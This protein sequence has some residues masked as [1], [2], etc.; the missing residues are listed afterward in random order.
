MPKI[1]MQ[2]PAAAA[3]P[4]D[5]G[6]T[7]LSPT[8]KAALAK[9]LTDQ[10]AQLKGDEVAN[11]YQLGT[12]LARLHKGSLFRALGQ[13]ATWREFLDSRV[14]LSHTQAEKWIVV[15]THFSEPSVATYGVEV[16]FGL[17]R[18]LDR[19][20]SPVPA[21]LDS[22]TV[23]TADGE[24]HLADLSETE[25]EKAFRTPHAATSVNAA[26][27]AQID[28]YTKALAV[29]GA[30]V[31]VSGTVA[32]AGTRVIFSVPLTKVPQMASALTSAAS[33]KARRPVKKPV[34]QAKKPVPKSKKTRR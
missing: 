22:L 27:Q 32:K 19:T 6:H 12:A 15:A 1:A 13:Y 31:H 7:R 16:L 21:N 4:V 2:I 10:V 26:D 29:L 9:Q 20:H 5:D 34:R 11:A 28:G 25:A 3:L 23:Q 30:D 17:A 14:K 18:S 8:E 24:K 33:T